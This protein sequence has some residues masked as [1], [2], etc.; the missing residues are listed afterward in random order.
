MPGDY[1]RFTFNPLEDHFGVLM[2][3]GR[4]MLDC[5]FNEGV[6]TLG[7]QFRVRMLDTVGRCVVPRETLEGFRIQIVGNSITIGRGRAY[8]HGILA[9]NHGADD[10][11]VPV[12]NENTDALEYDPI[13]EERRGVHAVA[14]ESQPY[15]PNA[16]DIFPVSSNQD[17]QLVYLDVWQRELTHVQEP[18]LV[19]KAVG[20]DT[21]T[22][23]QVVWQVKVL[24]NLPPGST[25][26]TPD[27]NIPGWLDIIQPSAGRLTTAAVGVP[28]SDDPCIIAPAGGFRGTENR[29]PER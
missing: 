18:D 17:P 20:V 29:P 6:E 27:E 23:V 13:I 1:T 14:Y 22:R 8:V 10:Q 16:A 7:R 3:Q 2:Q 5:D 19:E 28:A 12:D 21:A 15:L 4:V 24:P 11:G 25:C 26:D 9:E